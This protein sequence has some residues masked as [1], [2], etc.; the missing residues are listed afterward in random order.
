MFNIYIFYKYVYWYFIFKRH[1]VMFVSYSVLK[2]IGDVFLD[3]KT[4]LTYKIK[5][6]SPWGI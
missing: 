6:V 2:I 4:C 3:S 5:G 1:E